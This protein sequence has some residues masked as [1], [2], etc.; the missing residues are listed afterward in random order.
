MRTGTA[1]LVVIGVGAASAITALLIQACGETTD[2]PATPADAAVEATVADTAPP[3]E[4]APPA[5]PDAGCNTASNFT[6][7]IPDASIADGAS[8]SGIC[9]GCANA[10]CKAEVAA[11]NQ[12]CRCQNLMGE[13]LSCY[14]KN[15]TNA[16]AC[17]GGFITADQTTQGQGIALL[18]CLQTKCDDEC[19]AAAFQDAG[20]GG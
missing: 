16:T 20:D 8:T 2:N 12:N 3:K 14:L 11:C 1:R 7:Q 6:D 19:A 13:A 10:Q 18:R 15:P 5:D 9:V 17:A 4:A